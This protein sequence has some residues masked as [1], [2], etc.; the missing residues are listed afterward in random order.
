MS[1]EAKSDTIDDTIV[2][3]S[4]IS[5]SS[6]VARNQAAPEQKGD[7]KTKKKASKPRKAKR[8]FPHNSIEDCRKIADAIK[9]LNAGNPWGSA[10]VAKA[11]DSS[12]SNPFFYLTASSRD[13]GLTIGTRNT[14]KIEL[15]DLGKSLVYP[16]SPDEEYRAIENAFR[17]IDIFRKVYDYYQGENLPDIHYLKNTLKTEFGIDESLQDD[18]YEIYRKNINYLKSKGESLSPALREGDNVGS[19]SIILGE[20]LE[21]GRARCFRRNALLGE[22]R[23]I[24]FWLLRRSS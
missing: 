3:S 20:V 21:F 11:I 19:G 14:P 8:N 5:E 18:F 2:K 1:S 12:M 7:K 6:D 17:G 10:D 24:P 13:Y 9:D 15:A 16:K 22:N 4:E 23:C